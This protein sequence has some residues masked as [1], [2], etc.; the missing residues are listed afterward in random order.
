MDGLEVQRGPEGLD[1]KMMPTR[2]DHIIGFTRFHS[3]FLF[4][5]LETLAPIS[6]KLVLHLLLSITEQRH[7][8]ALQS[9]TSIVSS[10]SQAL[11]RGRGVSK[12]HFSCVQITSSASNTSMS[13]VR[14]SL[15]PE[16]K[17]TRAN[18]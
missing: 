4:P 1:I 12:K 10:V 7:L 16:T 5:S 3:F 18:L 6:L 14:M 17:E 13:T 15:V 11:P 8:R 2:L 9:L